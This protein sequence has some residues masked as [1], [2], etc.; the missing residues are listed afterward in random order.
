MKIKQIPEDF[1]V[2]ERIKL[3]LSEGRNSYFK[4]KKRGWT[5]LN[6]IT[7]IAERLGFGL[8]RFGYAGNKDRQAVTEQI[9]SIFDVPAERVN[10]LEIRDIELTFLGKGSR[11]INLGDL[12]GNDFIITVRDLRKKIAIKKK[13]IKNFYDEQRFGMNKNNHLV[14]KALIKGDFRTACKLIGLEADGNNYVNAL[15][16]VNR[17]MLIFYIHAYQSYLFNKVL[18]KVNNYKKIP[19]P[20]FLTKFKNKK[21]EKLYSNLLRKESVVLRDFII[22]P[23]KEISSEGSERNAYVSLKNLRVKWAKDELNSGKLKAIVSFSLG[24]GEYGTVVVKELFGK[25]YKLI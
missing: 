11:K 22:N 7:R 9:I 4:L 1:I 10:N 15:R 14:G 18:E 25:V 8:N 20:G 16:T 6:A 3:N 17:K 5:T 13:K 2:K 23:Y 24:K 21:I 19:V 12:D